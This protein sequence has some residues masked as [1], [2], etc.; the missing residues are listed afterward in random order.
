MEGNKGSPRPERV[1]PGAL[2]PRLRGNPSNR[3]GGIAV[4]PAPLHPQEVFRLGEIQALI[5]EDPL[6]HLLA[7]G[8]APGRVVFC[9]VF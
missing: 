2:S 6:R 8:I 7:S 9:S 4:S 3:G 1:R 5:G